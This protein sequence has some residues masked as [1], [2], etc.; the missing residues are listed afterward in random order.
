[1]A[2]G[3]PQLSNASVVT[4]NTVTGAAGETPVGAVRG[5]VQNN[6]RP[7]Q[8]RK[9][10]GTPAYRSVGEA[11]PEPTLALDYMETD[12]GQDILWAAEASQATIFLRIKEDGTNGRE[13]PVKVTGMSDRADADGMTELDVGFAVQGAPIDIGTGPGA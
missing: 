8:L 3:T 13:W 11:E 5:W 4:V 2:L 6:T 12:T 10:I 7:T 9:Y 1:M